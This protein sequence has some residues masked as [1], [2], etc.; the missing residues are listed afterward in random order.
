VASSEKEEPS[1]LAAFSEAEGE[2]MEQLEAELRRLRRE[3]GTLKSSL[4]SSQEEAQSKSSEAAELLRENSHLK[5]ELDT[6]QF[7]HRDE[8]QV[9][10]KQIQATRREE[11]QER[12]AQQRQEMQSL[13]AR[14]AEVEGDLARWQSAAQEAKTAAS[15]EKERFEEIEK[16]R[17]HLEQQAGD[18]RKER[19]DTDFVLKE[20]QSSWRAER[21]KLVQDMKLKD[22]ELGNLKQVL[23][24]VTAAHV[25][26]EEL[27]KWKSRCDE[28]Q[29]QVDQANRARREMQSAVGHMT[30]AACARGGDLHDL[31]LRNQYLSQEY[32]KQ[33]AEIKKMDL[34]KRDLKDQKENVEISLNY[35]QN[36]YKATAAALRKQETETGEAMEGLAQ[37]RARVRELQAE[38]KRG[39]LHQVPVQAREPLDKAVIVNHSPSRLNQAYPESALD[40]RRP[41]AEEHEPAANG[42]EAENGRP[43]LL[44]QLNLSGMFRS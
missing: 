21:E 44:S 10:R 38:L 27:Q 34:E 15:S 40:P 11:L 42:V 35:F 32:E 43:S 28:L 26:K 3:N 2:R 5:S 39:G 19:Q 22:R 8:L 18:L 6:I 7:T 33:V 17:R 37:A 23:D 24:N 36:K 25:P 13:Q 29:Q 31:Q 1:P 30:H 41:R 9:E 12:E 20:S 4:F 16:R 14:L